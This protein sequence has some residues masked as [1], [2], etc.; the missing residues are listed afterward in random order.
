M[1][2]VIKIRVTNRSSVAI[3]GF[4]EHTECMH[5]HQSPSVQGPG[6]L[7]QEIRP[8]ESIETVVEANNNIFDG[9]HG[10]RKHL[11]VSFRQ[12]GTIVRQEGPV[13]RESVRPPFAQLHFMYADGWETL[14]DSD[15]ANL[16]PPEHQF[17][18]T[19]AVAGET[20]SVT[21]TDQA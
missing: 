21:V 10:K 12:D 4:V 15:V 7:T 9:C 20:Y 6:P 8:G 3:R 17:A 13:T 18:R 16:D 1:G 5:G 2:E 14:G 11:V 19:L